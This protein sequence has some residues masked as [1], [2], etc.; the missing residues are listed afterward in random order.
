MLCLFS[1]QWSFFKMFIYRHFLLQWQLWYTKPHFFSLIMSIAYSMQ[2]AKKI[3]VGSPMKSVPFPPQ[4]RFFSVL[5]WNY[6][7]ILTEFASQHITWCTKAFRSCSTLYFGVSSEFRSSSADF[8]SFQAATLPWKQNFS[9]ITVHF[10]EVPCWTTPSRLPWSRPWCCDCRNHRA[11]NSRT[12]KPE[13]QVLLL[14]PAQAG[15]ELCGYLL[16]LLLLL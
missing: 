12:L 4:I 9:R 13:I 8:C 2:Q 1:G 14:L 6:V 3:L 16:L 15:P 7:L 5:T 10:F 11:L